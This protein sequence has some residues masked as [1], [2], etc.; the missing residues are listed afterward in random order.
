MKGLYY[1]IL[2]LMFVLGCA[3]QV[4]E[5]VDK[6]VVLNV[7]IESP[8]APEVVVVLHNDILTYELD[9]EGRAEIQLL[10]IDATY[11]RLFHGRDYLRMYVE[12]GDD[13][14]VAFKG[15]RMNSTYT[16]EGEKAPVVKYL[17]TVS[18]VALPD[19]DYALGFDE[20]RSRLEQ[21]ERM[22]LDC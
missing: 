2:P 18:L 6:D 12:G 1:L 19:E 21:K 15:G 7:K 5:G 9:E 14:T 13:A 10:G 22:L 17:N 4:K 3:G 11:L 8:V 16:F 20:Y